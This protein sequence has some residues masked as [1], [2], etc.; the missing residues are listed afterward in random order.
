M[1][2]VLVQNIQ[3]MLPAVF[4]LFQNGNQLNL[5]YD[6]EADVLYISLGIPQKAEDTEM[7]DENTLIRK[8]GDKVVGVTLLHYS[9]LK[10]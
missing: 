6:K 10:D 3:K 8:N 7:I 9:Q 1:E 4:P 5:R 2:K